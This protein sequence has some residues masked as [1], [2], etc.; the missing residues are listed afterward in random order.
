MTCNNTYVRYRAGLDS[1]EKADGHEGPCG[2]LNPDA[3]IVAEIS[4]SWING[5]EVTPG[6]GLLAEQFEHVINVNR[7]RGYRLRDFQ[8]VTV[9]VSV[10]QMNETIIAVF[11]KEK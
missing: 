3:V 10:N 11:E 9:M 8:I 7:F 1:C 2:P 4:K 6:S 5:H